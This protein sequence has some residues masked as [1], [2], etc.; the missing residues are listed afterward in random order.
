VSG[1]GVLALVVAAISGRGQSAPQQ[2]PTA[3][4]P[5]HDFRLQTLDYVGPIEEDPDPSSLTEVTIGWF[6][7]SD[8]H[9]PLHGDLWTAAALAVE[10][11]NQEG[12]L[13]GLPVRLVPRWSEN[14]WGSG[15]AQVARLVHE[16]H[17]RALVGAVDSPGTHLAEQVAVKARIVLV[18][19]VSTDESANLAG[20][21][22]M[23]SVVPGDHLWA[24]LLVRRLLES[25][26]NAGFAL[27]TTTDHDSRLAAREV[28]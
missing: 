24:P 22:W 15:V 19:P 4:A 27:L 5:Y 8:S 11:I 9:H 18:S 6:G 3:E 20:V 14:P 23:F 26:G 17:I 12:G 10:E 13:Q 16:E 21:P 2:P 1:V 25:I 28:L 7:P